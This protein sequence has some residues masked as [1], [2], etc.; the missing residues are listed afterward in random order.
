MQRTD[1]QWTVKEGTEIVGSDGEKVGKVVAVHDNYVVVEKGFLFPSDYYIP[2]TAI[3]NYDEKKIYLN[4]TKEQALEQ[5]PSWDRQPD[6]LAAVGTTGPAGDAT[7]GRGRTPA[8]MTEDEA[9]FDHYQDSARTH[10]Q[11]DQ[12]ITVPVHEEELTATRREVDLGVVR[13]EKEVVEEEQT[14][15]VPVTD[16][17]VTVQRRTVDRAATAGEVSFE[18]GVLDVPVRGEVVELQKRVRVTEEI[19]LGKELV[20]GTERVSGTVRREEVRVGESDVDPSGAR[21]E[22]APSQADNAGRKATR[23]SKKKGR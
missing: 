7:W 21:T 18:E 12:D 1:E 6:D 13:V 10:Q 9:P 4:V 3:A 19:E 14:L 16:E 23:R 11:D 8:G 20:Q 17:R 15:D 2:T 5:D 22:R